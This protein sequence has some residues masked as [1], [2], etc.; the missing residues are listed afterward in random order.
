MK[1]SAMCFRHGGI[2]RKSMVG[3]KIHAIFE[4]LANNAKVLCDK[5][6]SMLILP[7]AYLTIYLKKMEDN[8]RWGLTFYE[9]LHMLGF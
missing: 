8:D 2:D 1:F 5:T 7:P 9:M 3:K 6:R 4:H